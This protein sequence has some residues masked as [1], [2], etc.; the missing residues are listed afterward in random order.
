[1]R[2]SEISVR[3]DAGEFHTTS[4]V[5]VIVFADSPSQSVSLALYC[6]LLGIGRG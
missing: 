3:H 5:S 2:G 4:R 6:A 1:M